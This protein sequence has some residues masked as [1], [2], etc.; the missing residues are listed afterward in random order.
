M[1]MTTMLP[2]IDMVNHAAEG[3]HECNCRRCFDHSGAVVVMTS[4]AIAPGEELRHTY[5]P[6]A[7]RC[8]SFGDQMEDDEQLQAE[9][10]VKYGVPPK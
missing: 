9:L 1:M 2:M 7:A 6:E 4:R 3:T 5:A 10:T 8:R